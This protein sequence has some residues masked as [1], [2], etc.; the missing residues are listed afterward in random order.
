MKPFHAQ[1]EDERMDVAPAEPTVT[2]EPSGTYGRGTERIRKL[3][4]LF[5]PTDMDE[6]EDIE[7]GASCPTR[8]HCMRLV[9]L[10]IVFFAAEDDLPAERSVRPRRQLP[11]DWSLR[12]RDMVVAPSQPRDE[13]QVQES[14]V[15]RFRLTV[16]Y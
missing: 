9:R 6:F 5:G 8:N 11:L 1:E 16:S 4:T 15:R 3:A 12:P 7:T 10:T 2:E 13:P 14:K